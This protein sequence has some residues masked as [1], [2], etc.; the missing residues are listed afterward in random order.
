[1]FD[2]A[3]ELPAFG[4]Q[5]ERSAAAGVG[6]AGLLGLAAMDRMTE[7]V[8]R[9][10]GLGAAKKKPKAKK[11]P[12]AVNNLTPAPAIRPAGRPRVQALRRQLATTQGQ[13]TQAQGTITATQNKLARQQKLN[14]TRKRVNTK[15]RGKNQE[16]R[17][18]ARNAAGSPNP[19]VP[20]S[21]TPAYSS[22]PVTPI[23]YPDLPVDDSD[24]DYAAQDAADDAEFYDEVAVEEAAIDDGSADEDWSAMDPDSAFFMDPAADGLDEPVEFDESEIIGGTLTDESEDLGS[25]LSKT[26]KKATGT[27]LSNV[28]APVAGGLISAVPIVG[29]IAAPVVSGILTKGQ[30]QTSPNPTAAPAPTLPTVPKAKPAKKAKKTSPAMLIALA[31]LGFV[32]LKGSK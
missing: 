2:N 30:P 31:A 13:L 18:R 24:Y 12:A 21:G 6:P 25:W 14:A 8:D 28:V 27:S 11:K 9:Y 29:G 16:L 19:S 7:D 22:M 15:L 1:M 20:G 23:N 3:P 26:F 32:L 4:W 10:L 5:A 17:A